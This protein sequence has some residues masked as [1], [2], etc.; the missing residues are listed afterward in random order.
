MHLPLE[1]LLT[2]LES[3]LDYE[4]GCALESDLS[5][6]LDEIITDNKCGSTN[7]TVDD[8]KDAV[9]DECYSILSEFL[10][11]VV[12]KAIIRYK[13]KHDNRI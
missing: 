13:A 6:K 12:E 10:V 7:Y 9:K 1:D 4:I 11:D 8:L 3:D 2:R 5:D